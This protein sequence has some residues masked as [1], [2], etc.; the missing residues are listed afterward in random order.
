MSIL[1]D[2]QKSEL[3][4]RLLGLN[5]EPAPAQ[6]AAPERVAPVGTAADQEPLRLAGF[7]LANLTQ[8]NILVGTAIVLALIGGYG[9][10]RKAF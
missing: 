7:S 9:I 3:Y 10:L 2:A 5:R 6:A 1:S 4:G 8:Q